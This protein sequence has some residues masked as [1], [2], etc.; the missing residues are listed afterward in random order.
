MRN[1]DKNAAITRVMLIASMT[2][3][4]TVGLLVRYVPLASGELALYRAVMAVLLIGVYLVITR[5]KLDLSKIK[6]ALPLLSLSGAAIGF[7]WIF[8]FEAYKHT[9]VS[10]ATVSYYFAPVLVTVVSPILFKEKMT[11]SGWLCFALST[12]GILLI[13]LTGDLTAGSNHLVGIGFG[14]LAACLYAT[15]I[16]YC[17]YCVLAVFGYFKWISL[18]EETTSRRQSMPPRA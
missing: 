11:S 10:A 2:I 1:F 9:S 17:V 18:I 7:N 8:L 14:L 4:G 15:A 5:R 12:V 13:T 16:L 3:F 6:K